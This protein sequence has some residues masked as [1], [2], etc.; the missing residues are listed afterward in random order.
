MGTKL[1]RILDIFPGIHLV[2]FTQGDNW[3]R[4]SRSWVF[5]LDLAGARHLSSESITQI[6][7]L[8]LA[9]G[10][11]DNIPFTLPKQVQLLNYSLNR[12]LPISKRG[13][14]VVS[15]NYALSIPTTGHSF[16]LQHNTLTQT[17]AL[18]EQKNGRLLRSETW[19]SIANKTIQS[20]SYQYDNLGRQEKIID[21]AL[22]AT[23]V[24][25][26]G[27]SNQ[28][29]TRIDPAGHA[30]HFAYIPQDQANHGR[31]DK[32][33]NALGNTQRLTYNKKGQQTAVFGDS[34]YPLSYGYDEYGSRT[35]LTTYQAH[36]DS[37]SPPANNQTGA[38]T[39]WDYHPTTAALMVKKYADGSTIK[40]DYSD[41][42]QL[43]S[44][45]W[46]R[47]QD[48][49]L[50]THYDYDDSTGN[51]QN[52]SFGRADTSTELISY[53]YDKNRLS[54]ITDQVG[55]RSF[56]YDIAGRVALE[57]V[58]I[59]LGN[60]KQ[61]LVFK[62][63]RRY[64]PT[65]GQIDTLK[66]TTPPGA[67]V[68]LDHQIKY[69]WDH[70]Q[71]LHSVTS[72]A[73]EFV[74]HYDDSQR[75]NKITSPVHEMI[76][77]YE[78][79]RNLITQLKNQSLIGDKSIISTY[80]YINDAI[81]RRQSIT[82]KGAAFQQLQLYGESAIQVAYNDRSEVTGYDII[83][84]VKAQNPSLAQSYIY[85][86]IGN[87]KQFTTKQ[88]GQ[89]TTTTYLR[90]SINQYT[91]ITQQNPSA[92]SP[93]ASQPPPLHDEDGNLL[94]DASNHYT[95]NH[96]NRLIQVNSKDGKT[97]VEYTYD[98][99]GR[100]TTKTQTTTNQKQTTIYIYDG[101]NLLAE[102]ETNS[103]Q[104]SPS[105]SST[106]ASPPPPLVKTSKRFYT[107]GRDL[108]GSLQ[109]AGGVGGLLAITKNDDQHRYP[110]YD[111]NGNIGQMI[112][113]KAEIKA[114]YQYDA[115]GNV[116]D[117]T[118]EE[119]D[120]NPWRFSTKPVEEATGWYYYGYRYYDP[121]NGRWPSR[122]PIEESGGVNL[123]GFVG[124]DGFNK[125]DPV[126]LA[127]STFRLCKT[128]EGGETE[129][130][131]K[132]EIEREVKAFF[133]SYSKLNFRYVFGAREGGSPFDTG[134]SDPLPILRSGQML[135]KWAKD[136][137]GKAQDITTRDRLAMFVGIRADWAEQLL[138][139]TFTDRDW[140]RQEFNNYLGGTPDIGYYE[141]WD[142]TTPSSY[143]IELKTTKQKSDLKTQIVNKAV[144]IAHEALAEK[145]T[146][147]LINA[148][149]YL[150]QSSDV[151][152]NVEDDNDTDDD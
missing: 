75:L 87:R 32:T 1:L 79:N 46:A 92:S 151:T 20:L 143:I 74:Y 24:K 34:A 115:F 31:V 18:Q 80:D 93:P 55:K 128:K 138:F 71:R 5:P 50:A 21:A 86:S 81:G 108:S 103:Q 91:S 152:K 137:N 122:D 141:G 69:N 77:T 61:P 95:W 48:Q 30:T 14:I 146:S 60:D 133:D 63:N 105:V 15:H 64:H 4:V 89:E 65:T 120:E 98:Y 82:Q 10:W 136:R 44:R 40:Y 67:A 76:Y 85:D 42:G 127:E 147:I 139:E 84:D 6:N 132:A 9:E 113:P 37:N 16:R 66:L 123:Y 68:E 38:T 12:T 13:E 47:H 57:M 111:A 23:Q 109:G 72:G 126:G 129:W 100:R 145:K 110:C 96:E 124:N 101:W 53:D 8:T 134:L 88:Q 119:A 70:L 83:P 11:L 3:H 27:N 106:P 43:T 78:P 51:L 45:V 54:A 2:T 99:Q 97:K 52:V 121:K 28:V 140:K 131:T 112:S 149:G 117:K 41:I 104:Q 107:W 19:D 114:A 25:Y 59:N 94:E 142:T 36:D 29:A 144:K 130:K 102:I 118:G 90:N 26:H 56:N 49:G 135:W 148:R 150:Y 73:G 62:I 39:E 7:G 17:W 58:T 125:I 22:G 33:T 116:A 35:E